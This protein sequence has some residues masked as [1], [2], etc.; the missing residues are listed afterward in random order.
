MSL[1]SSPSL[2]KYK[3][4]IPNRPPDTGKRKMVLRIILGILSLV[5]VSLFV[6]HSVQSN[7]VALLTGRGTL[8]GT[9]VDEYG[10]PLQAQVFIFGLDR[11]VDTARDGIFI[12]KNIPAG[13]HSLI[14]AFNGT[15]QEFFVQVEAGTTLDLGT[16]AF[17][18][19][20]P[21][22]P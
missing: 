16:L 3:D 14:V 4:G 13:Q 9:V 2:Q 5:A 10:A 15:A 7:T 6:V 1:S 11:Q 18:V 19:S 17:L 22:Q 8:T 21:T 20:T 12:Y